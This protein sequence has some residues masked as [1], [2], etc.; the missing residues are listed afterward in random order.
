MFSFAHM[1]LLVDNKFDSS[2]NGGDSDGASNCNEPYFSFRVC[3][4]W[5]FFLR[6]AA[7]KER[8]RRIRLL[9]MRKD[10]YHIAKFIFAQPF[11]SHINLIIMMCT[12]NYSLHLFSLAV[13]LVLS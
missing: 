7:E 1:V 11:R 3:V 13:L 9:A 4:E 8:K 5:F 12:K 2:I 10:T 6:R